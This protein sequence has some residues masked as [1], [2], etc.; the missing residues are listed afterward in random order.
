MSVYPAIKL[1][2]FSHGGLAEAIRLAFFIGEVPFVDE[3]L[4]EEQF[5]ELK[6]SLPYGQVP[7][8][9]IDDGKVVVAQSQALLRYAGRLAKLYPVNNPLAALKIDEILNVLDELRIQMA[10]SFT[11]EDEAKKKE[12][13]EELAHAVIPQYLAMLE[14]RLEQLKASP[15]FQSKTR[16]YIHEIVVYLLLKHFRMGVLDHIPA[17]IAD[18]FPL[19]CAVFDKL[20]E[21]PKV[22]EWYTLA[23]ALPPKLTLTYVDQAGRAEPIRLAFFIGGVEFED[24]RISHEEFGIRKG[25]LPFHQL[26]VLQV[27]SEFLAQTFPILRYAGTLSGGELYPANDPLHAVRI[28][29]ILSALDEFDNLNT[30]PLICE[31]DQAKKVELSRKLTEE[32]IPEILGFL[33][34]RVEVSGGRYTCGDTLTVADLAI[35]SLV[36]FL[37]S[38]AGGDLPSTVVDPFDN[39]K[40]V[41]NQVIN[42]PKVAEWYKTHTR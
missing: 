42:H 25:L 31:K 22:K 18:P 30:Q 15:G 28:D 38:Q 26:P 39:L 20:Y 1:K 14:P 13:R 33:D 3:R 12:M 9:D 21:H 10:A 6:P 40:R 34:K 37:N 36:S 35:F 29:E 8:L 19:F 7:V 41:Y 16:V 2:Y 23:R 32:S 11:E 17:T 5:A 24:E 27:D 4:T